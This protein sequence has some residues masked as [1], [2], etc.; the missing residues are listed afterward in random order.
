MTSN[1]GM[2]AVLLLSVVATTTTTSAATTP[3]LQATAVP[4]GNEVVFACRSDTPAVWVKQSPDLA[5]VE[6][7]SHNGYP[8][9]NSVD[10]KR[11]AFSKVSEKWKE[12]R[13][14]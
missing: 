9:D 7:L 3:A 14:D 5:H 10:L 1:A 6:F 11:F 2:A 12:K 4:L 13:K 8:I